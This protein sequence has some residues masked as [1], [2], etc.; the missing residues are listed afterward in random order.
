MIEIKKYERLNRDLTAEDIIEL[1]KSFPGCFI[2]QENELIIH[3]KM[4]IFIMMDNIKTKRQLAAN[5]L[6]W[7]SREASESYHYSGRKKND[8][9]RNFVLDG[10]NHFLNTNFTQDDMRI[11]YCNLGGGANRDLAFKFIDS[12]Y[13]FRIILKHCERTTCCSL[14]SK[15]MEEIEKSKNGIN[16]NKENKNDGK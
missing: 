1:I 5:M 3:K 4:N 10:I 2:T 8:K 12:G 14:Y 6:Q 7:L 16:V 15:K 11:I 13:D 9:Y